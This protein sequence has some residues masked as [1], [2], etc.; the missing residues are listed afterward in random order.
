MEVLSLDNLLLPSGREHPISSVEDYISLLRN[1]KRTRNSLYSSPMYMHLC[2]NGLETHKELGNYLITM[3]VECGE[4]SQAH[5]L[6]QKLACQSEFSWSALIQGCVESENYDFSF[7]LFQDMQQQCIQPSKYT[8]IALL[9]AC[10]SKL[11]LKKGWKVHSDVVLDAFEQDPFVASALIDMYT[12]CHLP[13]EAADVFEDV[14]VRDVALWNTLIVSYADSA[15]AKDPLTCLR[16]MHLEGLC[17]DAVTYLCCVKA[18][19]S[20]EN[21]RALHTEMIIEGVENE[22]FVGNALVGAYAKYSSLSEALDVCGELTTRDA[23]SWNVLLAGCLEQGLFSD[24]LKYLKVMQREGIT[25]DHVSYIHALKA[26][27]SLKAM[28]ESLALHREIVLEGLERESFLTST[29]IDTYGKLGALAE[30]KDTLSDMPTR[31]VVSW[32]AMIGGLVEHDQHAEALGLLGAMKLEGVSPN[33]STIICCLRACG[34]AGDMGMGFKLH[35]EVV[36]KGFEIDAFVGNALVDMYARCGLL[37]E[38][39]SVFNVLPNRDVVSWTSLITAYAEQGLAEDARSCLRRMQL[40]GIVPDVVAWNAVI[41][42]FSELEET[43]VALEL[44]AQMQ[45]QGFLPVGS[46]FASILNGCSSKASLKHGRRVHSQILRLEQ[47]EAVEVSLATAL[48]DMYSKCSSISEAEEVFDSML[49]RSLVVWN[50]L[51]SGYVRMGESALAFELFDR[52]IDEGVEP[53]ET[54]FLSVLTLCTHVGLVKKG[55]D[56]FET[57]VFK[58]GII[59]KEK[60]YNCLL[61]LLGRAGQLNEALQMF[62]KLPSQPD[63]A[64]WNTFIGA[65][66]RW[67]DIELG[68]QAFE[69][70]SGLDMPPAA[71]FVLMSNLY[72][73][74]AA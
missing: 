12:S 24:V 18:C 61:D 44:F 49:T 34:Y 54:A 70:S 25:P 55:L 13:S 9:K 10:A 64:T 65:C 52:M 69:L 8:Y 62:S 36:K 23:I 43:Q 50:A 5:Q 27:S 31:S 26:C 53:D 41:S 73:D 6:F 28:D 45:E 48:V 39:L 4:W 60:H 17:P 14:P 35:A 11:S 2:H 1:C 58:Y 46:T 38:S 37:E 67:G 21:V 57:M 16:Q 47:S 7:D 32:T 68:E 71:G 40:E 72:A 15:S 19:K 42:S 22:G 74:T 3:L 63:L 33:C 30:A 56:Y 66:Q 20:L 51:M 59:P 29:L